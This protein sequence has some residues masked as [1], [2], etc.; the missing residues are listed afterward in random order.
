[1]NNSIPHAALR[2]THR[3]RVAVHKFSSCDGC[4]LAFLNLG[5]PLLALAET[6]DILHF[7]E[8]GPID[9]DAV[10]DIAFVEGSVAT[11][12]DAARLKQIR[13]NSRYVITIGACAT[14]GGIQALRN[15]HDSG[16]WIAGIYAQP[17]Y[18][19]LLPESRPIA[20]IIKVDLELWGCPVNGEQVLGVTKALLTGHLPRVDHSAV[21]MECK[22]QNVVCVM[23]SQGKPCMGPVTQ[24]GC[25]AICP[26]MQ[27]DCYACY[28]PAVQANVSAL[29]TYF[30]ATGMPAREVAQRLLFINSQ[31]EPFTSVGI[32]WQNKTSAAPNTNPGINPKTSLGAEQ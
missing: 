15:M 10:V 27:R 30:A 2:S 25:G 21:C 32:H 11:S 5:E 9:E 14:A 17:E 4:Q 31:T 6:V 7:A 29:S 26:K 20:S 24:T 28:G 8:A 22:R 3:P 13:E 1:M 23:V 16:E 12:K 18:L 19:D